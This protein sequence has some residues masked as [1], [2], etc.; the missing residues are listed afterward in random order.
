MKKNNIPLINE[1]KLLPL[2][3]KDDIQ[4]TNVTILYVESRK[5]HGNII[6]LG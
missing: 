4:L 3:N 2:R 6:E 1:D 5:D